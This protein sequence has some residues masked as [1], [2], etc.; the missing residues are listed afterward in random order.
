MPTSGT[1][2]DWCGQPLRKRRNGI[3]VD[4]ATSNN[5]ICDACWAA[6]IAR[7]AGQSRGVALKQP[8]VPYG[9]R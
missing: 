9:P 5:L 4:L 7:K 8:E 1:K 6:H 2:C 3:V